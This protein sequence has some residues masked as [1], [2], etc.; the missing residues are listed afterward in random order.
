MGSLVSSV[1]RPQNLRPSALGTRARGSRAA[2]PLPAQAAGLLGTPATPSCPAAPGRPTGCPDAPWNRCPGWL[3]SFGS[4]HLGGLVGA[5]GRMILTSWSLNFLICK[6]GDEAV[7]G[8]EWEP[9]RK[10]P[11]KFVVIRTPTKINP[12]QRGA[13]LLGPKMLTLAGLT[14]HLALKSFQKGTIVIS[15][16]S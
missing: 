5:G 4:C 3:P 1:P 8:D 2:A 15:S 7:V 16:H 14:Q 9:A 6:R 10:V 13:G 12:G 11:G